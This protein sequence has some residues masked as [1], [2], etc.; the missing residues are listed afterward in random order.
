MFHGALYVKLGAR[1]WTVHS[2]KLVAM[3]NVEHTLTLFNDKFKIPI[4]IKLIS[5]H[6][7]IYNF[8]F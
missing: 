1:I 8:W 5:S 2:P 4:V 6:K 7:V 3:Y